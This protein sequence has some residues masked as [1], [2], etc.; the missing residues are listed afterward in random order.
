MKD[1]VP[2]DFL[3]VV[4]PCWNDAGEALALARAWA[5]YPAVRE[6]VLAGVEGFAPPIASANDGKILW[7]ASPKPSRGAQM[8][9]G[10]QMVTGDALLFHHVDSILTAAHIDAIAGPLRD[11]AVIGGGFHRAFDERHPSLRW[12]EN[13][14]RNH[15]RAFGTIYGDQSVFVRRE[16]FARLGGFADIPLMEDVEF[17]KRLRRAG[18]VALLDPPM[19]SSPNRQLAQGAWRVTLRN[20]SFLIAFRLGLSPQRMHD[21]YYAHARNLTQP[22]AAAQRNATTPPLVATK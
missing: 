12:L 17:S 7:C 22:S 15:S 9:L 1:Y 21:R 20:L 16:V 18:K 10:A 4:V 2:V 6:I 5:S 14:E 3:S 11:P 8:N 19:R 13:L